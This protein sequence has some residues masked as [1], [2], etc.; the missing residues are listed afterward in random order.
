MDLHPGNILTV[1]KK[2]LEMCLDN[3]IFWQAKVL[4][5]KSYPLVKLEVANAEVKR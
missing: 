3:V 2:T 1:K 5:N 4:K